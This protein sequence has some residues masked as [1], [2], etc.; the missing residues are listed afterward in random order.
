M[1]M[2]PVSSKRAPSRGGR[3]APV[4]EIRP[5]TVD[6]LSP[7]RYIHT[8]AFAQGARGHYSPT[9][10]AAFNEF[11]RSSRY[12]DLMLGN[13][14]VAAW[15]GPE[16]V[17]T[18]AWS[19]GE[20]RSPTARVFGVFVRPMFTGEGIGRRIVGHVEEEARAAGYPA[21]EAAATLNATPFFEAIGFR[22]VRAGTWALP[23]GREIA[24]AFLRKA[25]L[26]GL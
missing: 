6:E 8:A 4:V 20:S 24:V 23:T 18:A 17:A 9:D 16:M 14:A 3:L 25:E 15:L 7:A 19:P 2:G 26:A 5:L 21:L 22:F 11:A 13:P 10:I 1:H 12:A